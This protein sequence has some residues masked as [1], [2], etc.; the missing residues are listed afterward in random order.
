MPKYGFTPVNV[1]GIPKAWAELSK[2][3]GKLPLSE[4]VA[5]AVKLAREGYAVP[6]NVAKLWKKAAVN[7]EKKVEKNSNTGLKLLLK[8][9]NALR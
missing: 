2:K 1:P 4:V 5:P 7:F 6:V 9:E 3:F 8:M